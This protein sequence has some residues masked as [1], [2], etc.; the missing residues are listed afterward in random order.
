MASLGQ[1]VENKPPGLEAKPFRG[2]TGRDRPASMSR[3]YTR[4]DHTG[5][6]TSARWTLS[7]FAKAAFGCRSELNA[8]VLAAPEGSHGTVPL[9]ESEIPLSWLETTNPQ[10]H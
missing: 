10:H 5:G 1:Q 4:S 9:Q 8:R 2:G 3:V 7:S 6:Q